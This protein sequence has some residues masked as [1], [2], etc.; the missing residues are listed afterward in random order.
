MI[1]QRNDYGGIILVN[2]MSNEI[3]KFIFCMS[4][5]FSIFFDPIIQVDPWPFFGISAIGNFNAYIAKFFCRIFDG[6]SCSGLNEIKGWSFIACI[7]NAFFNF[8]NE[9]ILGQ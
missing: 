3:K 1:S 9:F 6:V 7:I 2:N 8:I 4:V 5:N